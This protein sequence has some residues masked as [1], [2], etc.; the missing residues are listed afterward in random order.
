M[1]GIPQPRHIG[2]RHGG[3]VNLVSIDDGITCS[4]QI[5]VGQLAFVERHLDLGDCHDQTQ[6]YKTFLSTMEGERIDGQ[7]VALRLVVTTNTYPS[8]VLTELARGIQDQLDGVYIEK[9]NTTL[10]RREPTEEADDLIRLMREQ[11]STPGVRQNASDTIELFRDILPPEIRSAFPAT[12]DP[13]FD[14]LLNELLEEAI[15]E[16][17]VTVH[18]GES[19]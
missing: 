17:T 10:P 4:E 12:D 6:V 5:K 13:Q 2:E 8:E 11:L 14:D 7:D 3:F 9:I 18:Q 1:P 16:V 19:A 15:K